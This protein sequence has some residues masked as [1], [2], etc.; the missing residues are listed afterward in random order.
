MMRVNKQRH[1]PL[2]WHLFILRRRCLKGEVE[3]VVRHGSSFAGVLRQPDIGNAFAGVKNLNDFTLC[4]LQG[5]SRDVTPTNLVDDAYVSRI[6]LRYIVP[7][8]R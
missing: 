1:H 2:H 5:G 6:F 7:K 3:K 8:Y 4:W